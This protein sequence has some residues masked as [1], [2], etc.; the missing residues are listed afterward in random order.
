MSMDNGIRE[1]IYR[2]GAVRRVAQWLERGAASRWRAV[3]EIAPNYVA[4]ARWSRG[5][6]L[7][8]I[9][10]WRLCRRTRWEPRRWRP[11]F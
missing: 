2:N 8:K 6:G 5:G 9:T 11:I 3:C 7:W 4:A 10:P 1:G